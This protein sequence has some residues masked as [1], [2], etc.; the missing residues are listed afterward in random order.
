MNRK[1]ETKRLVPPICCYCD[2]YLSCAQCGVEQPSDFIE[3][4]SLAS[5][6]TLR[7]S[8]APEEGEWHRDLIDREPDHGQYAKG[9][10]AN[11]LPSDSGKAAP[12]AWRW[13]FTEPGP[14]DVYPWQYQDFDPGLSANL[15]RQIEVEPLYAALAPATEGGT[16]NVERL[17]RLIGQKLAQLRHYKEN[18]HLDHAR[19][20]AEGRI[21]QAEQIG[22]WIA[23][24]SP[25]P[26]V[27]T[28]AQPSAQ[29]KD[30]RE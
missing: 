4:Q 1:E 5:L 3:R 30:A 12:D 8:A 23:D 10:N 13:R 14:K 22:H 15:A 24:L 29:S 28:P 27:G 19:A 17:Q 25:S 6:A 20:V 11:A 26:S 21:Q 16:F 2:H 18:C 9:G 7:A